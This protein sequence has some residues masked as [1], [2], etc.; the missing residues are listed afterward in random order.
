[1]F[2]NGVISRGNQGCIFIEN[3]YKN[4]ILYFDN[5]T[6]LLDTSTKIALNGIKISFNENL[7]NAHSIHVSINCEAL[8]TVN[9]NHSLRNLVSVPNTRGYE[10]VYFKKIYFKPIIKTLPTVYFVCSNPDVTINYLSIV[11][12]NKNG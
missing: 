10:E 6:Q 9:I 3:K 12:N 1:M 7:K 8:N 11:F 2:N 4:N 5:S